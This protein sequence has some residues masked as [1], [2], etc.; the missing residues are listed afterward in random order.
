MSTSVGYSSDRFPLLFF[1]KLSSYL[2][3]PLSLPMLPECDGGD[4]EYSNGHLYLQ[5]ASVPSTD[6]KQL[7]ECVSLL[8]SQWNKCIRSSVE[9]IRRK[10][11]G[12]GADQESFKKK[13][14]CHAVQLD[15]YELLEINVCSVN[16]HTYTTKKKLN[17]S[18]WHIIK[19]IFRCLFKKY[20]SVFLVCVA[21]SQVE[22]KSK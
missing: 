7:V 6:V 13:L 17:C 5:K 19:H 2:C 1:Q 18:M 10:K 4:T 3:K 14:F 16:E 8:S 15:Q 12:K 21:L 9:T 22:A 11:S 20:R